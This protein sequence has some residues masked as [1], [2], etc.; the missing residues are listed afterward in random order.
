MSLG[1]I[2]TAIVTVLEFVGHHDLVI[3][4]WIFLVSK[5]EKLVNALMH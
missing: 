3:Q 4:V 2:I 1:V 5:S